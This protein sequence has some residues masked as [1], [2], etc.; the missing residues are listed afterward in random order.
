MATPKKRS[1]DFKREAAAL[2]DG[3][4]NSVEQRAF[5]MNRVMR[6]ATVL[7]TATHADELNFDLYADGGNPAEYTLAKA[8]SDLDVLCCQAQAVMLNLEASGREAQETVRNREEMICYLQDN[9]QQNT[10]GLLDYVKALG[11]EI[12]MLRGEN[13]MLRGELDAAESS[14]RVDSV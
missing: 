14:K 7:K 3:R 9:H 11:E 6:L 2:L 4:Y 13:K 1:R 12:E 5:V 8:Y 10:H